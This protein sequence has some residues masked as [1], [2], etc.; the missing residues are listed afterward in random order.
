MKCKTNNLILILTITLTDPVTY[1]ICPL[2]DKLMKGGRTVGGFMGAALP[3]LKLF[4]Q[5]FHRKFI[6]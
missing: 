2:L 4:L 5:Q 6:I 1:F 3:D